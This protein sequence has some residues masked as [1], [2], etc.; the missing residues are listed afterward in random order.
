MPRRLDDLVH[1]AALRLADDHTRR[2]FLG[3]SALGA[4]AVGG[5]AL[6]ADPERALAAGAP[7]GCTHGARTVNVCYS[8]WRVMASE[9]ARHLPRG[10][11]GVAVRKG[12]SPTAPVLYAD[13]APVIVPVGG[14]FGR[15]SRRDGG[16]DRKCPDPGPRPA[17]GEGFVFGYAL[18]DGRPTKSGWLAAGYGNR[19][20]ADEDTS[21]SEIMCGPDSLDF[22]CRG[23]NAS[24]PYRKQCGPR[25]PGSRERS[26]F[27]CG[28]PPAPARSCFPA[29]PTTVRAVRTPDS[30]GVATDLSAERYALRYLP[31]GT[32][33]F[34][35]SPG[36]RVRAFCVRCLREKGHPDCPPPGLDAHSRVCCASASCVEVISAAWVPAGARGWV[37][38][39]VLADRGDPPALRSA[40]RQIAREVFLI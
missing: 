13:G 38:S 3:R 40:L 30:Q 8:P 23:D 27:Q 10:Q 11:R 1:D 35:L 34:W 29:Q 22:D 5:A 4:V 7:G 36:D 15:Q 12:P 39:T 16:A 19:R 9:P 18:R 2:S 26:G 37:D 31:G 32:E 33:L 6:A 21:A 24:S 25:K 14:V 20:F 17:E 28:G